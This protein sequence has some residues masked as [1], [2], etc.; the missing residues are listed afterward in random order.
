[1][2]CGRLGFDYEN[3]WLPA[4]SDWKRRN[5]GLPVHPLVVCVPTL[6]TLGILVA[7]L[8]YMVMS[9]S[10]KRQADACDMASKFLARVVG[11]DWLTTD[12]MHALIDMRSDECTVDCDDDDDCCH[13]RG[14]RRCLE[15]SYY[16]FYHN[17]DS[18]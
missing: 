8:S 1:M 17:R 3:F 15:D 6:G 11:M 10:K 12:D 2:W 14:P 5:V 4:L 18:K 13:M 16:C 7:L 9:Q